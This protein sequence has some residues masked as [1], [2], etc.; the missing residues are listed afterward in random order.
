MRGVSRVVAGFLLGS[1]LAVPQHAAAQ[2]APAQTVKVGVMLPTTGPGAALATQMRA[3]YELAL[4]HLGGKLGGRDA[5]LV[6][7]DTQ[8]KPEVARELADELIKSQKVQ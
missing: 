7:V 6:Y 8:A 5:Q 3:A 4:S 2:S 1:V